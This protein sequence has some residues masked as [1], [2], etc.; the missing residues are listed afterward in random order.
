MKNGNNIDI[1]KVAQ[2][3]KIIEE[4]TKILTEMHSEYRINMSD[5]EI[6]INY[7]GS[8]SLYKSLH[9]D[10]SIYKLDKLIKDLK[11]TYNIK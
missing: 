1:E 7:K 5:E 8:E 3:V 9:L 10:S 4:G 6:L 11:N 2:A